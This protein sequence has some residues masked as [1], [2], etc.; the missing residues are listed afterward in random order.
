MISTIEI[1]CCYAREDQELL[2]NLK[3]H[4][5]PLQRQGLITIWSD[6]DIT[7]G[8]TWEEEINQH[9]NTAHIILLLV[10]PDF[11]ASEYCYSKEMKQ[12]MQRHERGE[13]R[14]IP[15]ILRPTHWK[16]APFDKLQALPANASPVID[17]S[18]HTV[19]DAL[20]D[21]AEQISTV[22]RDLRIQHYMAEADHLY[23]NHRYEEA[24][25]IYDQ[26]IA[27]FPEYVPEYALAHLGKGETL[28]ALKRYQESLDILDKAIQVDPK[29]TSAHFHQS[30]AQALCNLQRFEESLAAYNEA[31]RLDPRTPHFYADKTDVLLHLHRYPEA[32]E[33]SEQL[34]RLEPNEAEHYQHKGEL[35]LQL[36]NWAEALEAY[37]Q[38]IRLDPRAAFYD[39]KG[40]LLLLLRKYEEALAA[41]E[42]AIQRA[43]K[44]AAYHLKKGEVLLRLHRYEPALATYEDARTCGAESNPYT[45]YGTGEALL[46]LQRYEQALAAYEQALRVAAPDPDPQ[47]HHGEGVAHDY[48]AQHHTSLA[49]QAYER[50]KQARLHWKAKENIA[51]LLILSTSSGAFSLLRILTGHTS[52]VLSVAF[53]PDGLTLASG[54]HDN[55]IKLWEVP[56]GRLLRTLTEHTNYVSSV[57]F[58]PYG[59]TL[60]SGSIDK[61]IKL[62]G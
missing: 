22:V 55:T 15:I 43:P 56:T 60:A 31:I 12:A 18:W 21:V 19:D 33:T 44:E 49:Q 58:S 23:Q 34:I 53:S 28:L 36:R 41:S 25:V 6:T 47:F 38:A 48:L 59:L 46:G 32:L 30:R 40:E 24:L 14:V 57:A 42:Q 29:L 27:L 26:V 62:W 1:F 4:L 11:I 2:R 5:M 39:K 9:L 50:E 54:S 8:A 45:Y 51:L 20:Y 13:A 10:S 52:Y 37:E 3:K 16:G 61:T 7:A 17:Q 35:L